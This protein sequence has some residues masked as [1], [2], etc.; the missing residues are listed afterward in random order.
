VVLH[1]EDNEM[2]RNSKSQGTRRFEMIWARHLKLVTKLGIAALA[3]AAL[4]TS[5]NA[6]DALTGKFTLPSETHWG[7]AT[8][9]AGDYTF[10]LPTTG[11]PYTLY[12]Q[13]KGV[14]VIIVASAAD[15]KVVSGHAQL[16]LV[17]IA[18]VQNVETFEAPELGLKFSYA[19]PKQKHM[20]RKEAHQK[21]AP[22]TSPA[23]Q[24]SENKT[25]IQVRTTGR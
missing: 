24:V 5:G 21:M 4:A 20:G 1:A 17:N 18:D 19:T 23:S 3:L 22:Q 13:G 9:P 15:E 10:A 12:V 2:S 16:N 14:S 6:R 7:I 25:S 8:L 11:F